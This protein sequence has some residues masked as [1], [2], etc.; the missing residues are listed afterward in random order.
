MKV[1]DTSYGALRSHVNITRSNV[2]IYAPGPNRKVDAR[3][4]PPLARPVVGLLC[5]VSSWLSLLVLAT[6]TISIMPMLLLWQSD[7][8]CNNIY[9]E[10]TSELVGYDTTS[11]ICDE[12]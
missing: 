4:A 6:H 8:G 1:V 3:E 5:S 9:V 12:A 11:D 10:E 2:R 7:V